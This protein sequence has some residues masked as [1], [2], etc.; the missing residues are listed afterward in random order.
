MK[1]PINI[2]EFTTDLCS[3]FNQ[4]WA[5]SWLAHAIFQAVFDFFYNRQSQLFRTF[6]HSLGA[7]VER[8]IGKSGNWE[9]K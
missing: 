1:T 9:L 5:F 8:S 2:N 6:P 7:P 4:N 3:F